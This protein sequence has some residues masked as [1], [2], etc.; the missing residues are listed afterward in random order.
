M[1]SKSSIEDDQEV[2]VSFEEHEEASA[3]IGCSG[4]LVATG[5]VSTYGAKYE[6]EGT[7]LQSVEAV[8]MILLSVDVP[9]FWVIFLDKWFIFVLFQF[10]FPS[11]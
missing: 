6:E 3:Y 5:F 2:A 7:V 4:E 1:S 8:L 9:V 10:R 11:L